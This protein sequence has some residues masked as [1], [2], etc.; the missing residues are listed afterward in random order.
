MR[1]DENQ[2]KNQSFLSRF[3]LEAMMCDE[4]MSTY[5]IV[6]YLI[7][8]KGLVYPAQYFWVRFRHGERTIY[9]QKGADLISFAK[10]I[11][12]TFPLSTIHFAPNNLCYAILVLK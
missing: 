6:L 5:F 3:A 12:S 10:S 9:Q 4:L 1:L 11:T 7:H 8:Y 2:D